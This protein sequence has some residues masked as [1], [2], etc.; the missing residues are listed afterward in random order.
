VDDNRFEG[1]YNNNGGFVTKIGTRVLQ[2]FLSLKDA[3]VARDFKGQ[4]LFAGY[5]V[6]DDGVKAG[7]TEL[8]DKAILK[9][10][11]HTRALIVNTTHSTANRRGA[12]TMPS[13]LLFT[14]DKPVTAEQLKAELLRLVKQRNLEFGVVVRRIS[15]PQLAVSLARS[16]VIVFSSS[17]GPGSIPIDPLV[18]ACKVFPDGHEEPVR[19]VDITG[20]SIG[21]FRNILAV[22]EPSAV[23]T[24]PPRITSRVPFSPVGLCSPLGPRWSPPTFLLCYLRMESESPQRGY[25]AAAL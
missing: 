24:A 6:D 18:E 4:P 1:I 14:A 5:L 16:R 20:L 3:P 19:N 23:Y 8:V 13:N 22:S 21:D 12:Q 15:N 2:E 17:N 7:E 10:L 11:L 9:T 25:S